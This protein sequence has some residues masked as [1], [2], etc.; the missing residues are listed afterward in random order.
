MFPLT[1]ALSLKGEGTDLCALLHRALL[2]S[3]SLWERAGVRASARMFP[4]TLTLSLKGEGTDLCALLHRAL[5]FSLSLWERAGVRASARTLPLPYSVWLMYCN[6]SSAADTILAFISYARCTVIIATISLTI[7]TFE[8]SSALS[9][10]V[11]SPSSPGTPSV[12]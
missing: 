6:I 10:K 4:L 1:L 3:L 2:F 5:L 7:S 12:G 8:P 11:P 9:C